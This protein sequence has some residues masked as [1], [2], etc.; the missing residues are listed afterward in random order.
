MTFEFNTALAA[1]YRSASQRARVLTEDW[2]GRNLYCPVCGHPKLCHFE[3]NKPVA[4]FYC[5]KCEAQF[6]LKSKKSKSSKLGKKIPA[7][8]YE[9]MKERVNST[10]NPHFLFLTYFD[11]TVRNLVFIPNRFFVAD[12]IIEKRKPLPPTARRAGW[13]GSNI[14]LARIPQNAKI[15]LVKDSQEMEHVRVNTSSNSKKAARDSVRNRT[16]LIDVS[17]CLDH[18]KDEFSLAEVYVYVDALR[19]SH[20]Q[21]MNIEAKIRQQLQILRNLGLLQFVKR[22]HYRKIK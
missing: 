14:N 22:G 21:N 9:K 2:V 18:L 3:A 4:D 17:R 7:G 8:D 16:W 1:R 15:F 6:E 11:D 12:D 13:V 19:E 20:P 10:K 5:E